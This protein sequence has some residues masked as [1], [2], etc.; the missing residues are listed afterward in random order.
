MNRQSTGAGAPFRSERNVV[1]LCGGIGGAKLA[2]GLY[3]VLAPHCLTVVVN[4]GDDFEHLGLHV[5]PDLDTV[6][7]TLAGWSDPARGWG[8]ADETWHFMDALAA[9][10]GPQ[11]FRLGDRDLAMHVSRTHW[12]EQGGTLSGFARHAAQ[13]MGIAARILPMSD[14]AVRTLVD[15][16]DGALPFQNYF[17][18]RG[19]AP[20]VTGIS[21]AGAERAGP[22]PELLDALAGP[23]LSA[24]VICP[25]NPYLSIDPLLAIPGLRAAL[26][27]ASAP[28]IAVSPLVGGKAVKGPTAKIMAELG[29]DASSLTIAAHY[30]GLI[31]GLVIDDSDAGDAARIDMPVA[32]TA[33]LMRDMDDRERLARDV[34]AFADRIAAPRAAPRRA[35]G[36]TR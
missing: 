20:A 7:Y 10:D 2:L 27:A 8:R 3:R 36:V 11:W 24:V 5:S 26:A 34:L 31:D 35:G 15:T 16:A 13:R 21:F 25:S 18:E 9:L 6:L 28:I 17:V 30:R 19:C 23:D 12:L 4:T 22:V 1:A 32:V 33:T 29:I 14:D